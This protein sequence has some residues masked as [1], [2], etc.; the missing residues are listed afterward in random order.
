[1]N[2]HDWLICTSRFPG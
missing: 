1:M 2:Y